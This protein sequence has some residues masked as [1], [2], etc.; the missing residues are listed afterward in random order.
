MPE[1]QLM[2]GEPLRPHTHCLAPSHT[3]AQYSSTVK[4]IVDKETFLNTE[5]LI[6][7]DF[8]IGIVM[9]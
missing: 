2:N 8:N 9:N 4:M 6:I 3:T 7:L 5:K 1:Q